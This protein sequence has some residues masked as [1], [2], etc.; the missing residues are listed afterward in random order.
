MHITNF[1]THLHELIDKGICSKDLILSNRKITLGE[2]LWII[3]NAT[4]L[5]KEF[6]DFIKF[7]DDNNIKQKMPSRTRLKGRINTD[8]VTSLIFSSDEN[9]DADIYSCPLC[10][11]MFGTKEEFSEH[12]KKAKFK[13]NTD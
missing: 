8:S 9:K 10:Q 13:P 1:A 7:C 12:K 11:G 4:K 2:A 6:Q 5:E 3:N